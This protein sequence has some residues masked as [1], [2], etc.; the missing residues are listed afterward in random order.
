MNVAEL[1][2]KEFSILADALID[3][4]KKYRDEIAGVENSHST[5][6]KYYGYIVEKEK[7]ASR[8]FDDLVGVEL[9]RE[10]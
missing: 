5:G 10:D 1:S 7:L 4:G 3:I 2:V 8:L 9:T 6:S